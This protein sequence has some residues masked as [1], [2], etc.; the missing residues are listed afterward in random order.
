MNLRSSLIRISRTQIWIVF[1][2]QQKILIRSMWIT[3]LR[4]LHWVVIIFKS[5]VKAERVKQCS[6]WLKICFSNLYSNLCSIYNLTNFYVAT[7]DSTDL[8]K[9]WKLHVHKLSY[10][11]KMIKT[12]LAVSV[13]AVSVKCLFNTVKDVCHYCWDQLKDQIIESI[14]IV[15]HDDQ[16]KLR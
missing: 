16:K 1:Y 5:T 13:T 4:Y 10:L 2:F 6:I 14:I 9:Y 11:K 3:V 15:K 8:L 7:L 12:I